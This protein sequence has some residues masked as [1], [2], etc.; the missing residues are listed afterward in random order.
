MR[1]IASSN[2]W[3]QWVLSAARLNHSWCAF[4]N[5]W[6]SSVSDYHLSQPIAEA[7]SFIDKARAVWSWR[8]LFSTT[9]FD[10]ALQRLPFTNAPTGHARWISQSSTLELIAKVSAGLSARTAHSLKPPTSAQEPSKDSSLL[11]LPRDPEPA[12]CNVKPKSM[13]RLT[14]LYNCFSFFY[15][16]WY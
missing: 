10:M 13:K 6:V 14:F 2:M 11:V 1:C 12:A 16:L 3:V 8:R 4:S 15:L 9:M 5:I 7:S